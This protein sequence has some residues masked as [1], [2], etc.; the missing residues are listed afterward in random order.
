MIPIHQL[1]KASGALGTRL[2][3]NINENYKLTKIFEREPLKTMV[4]KLTH[5]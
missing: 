5:K 1:A 2:I 4:Y 3:K